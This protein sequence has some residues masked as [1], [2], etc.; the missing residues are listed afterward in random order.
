MN[1]AVRGGLTTFLR[2]R[3]LAAPDSRSLHQY[4]T[5]DDEINALRLHLHDLTTDDWRAHECAVLV[6]LVSEWGHRNA[7]TARGFLDH[8]V[9]ALNVSAPSGPELRKRLGSGLGVW[10]L[11]L[12]GRGD[13]TWNSGLLHEGGYPL[14]FGREGLADLVD[15]IRKAFSWPGLLQTG[16]EAL[17][18]HVKAESPRFP[19]LLGSDDDTLFFTDLLRKFAEYCRLL[20]R[21]DLLPGDREK[22]GYWISRIKPQATPDNMLPFRTPLDSVFVDAFFPQLFRVN[23][24]NWDQRPS[25]P[26]RTP[27]PIPVTT[28]P[29]P[30]APDPELR[31]LNSIRARSQPGRP[32]YTYR[33]TEEEFRAL[34]EEVA[35]DV[36]ARRRLV[37]HRAGRFCL[38]A[39]E[40]L[41]R[42]YAGGPWTW[43]P[44]LEALAWEPTQTDLPSAVRSG[45]E[46][47]Q[48]PIHRTGNSQ[49]LLTTLL[50]EGGLPLSV[51]ADGRDRHLKQYFR[52]LIELSERHGAS[53]ER[54]VH[55]QIRVLPRSFRNEVVSTLSS[56]LADAVVALRK[57]LP[58]DTA[59]DPIAHL[60][61]SDPAWSANLP[62]RVDTGTFREFLRGLLAEPRQPQ[63]QACEPLELV[64]VLHHAAPV[65]LERR[66]RLRDEVSLRDMS[67]FL[68]LTPEGLKPR[69]RFTL[70]MVTVTG[71]RHAVAI[72]RLSVDESTYRL[73]ELPFSPVRDPRSVHHD[74]RIAATTG[75]TEFAYVDVAGGERLLED[76][77]WVFEGG[78]SSRLLAQ[79]SVR[80]RADEVLVLCPH[81]AAPEQSDGL[82]KLPADYQGRLLFSIRGELSWRGCGELWNI[83][84]TGERAERRFALAGQASRC[85]FTGSDF[86]VGMPSV[87]A[88][89][90]DRH[91]TAVPPSQIEVRTTGSPEWRPVGTLTGELDVR[92]RD[93]GE[94]IFRGA[95][96]ALP[97]GTE[98]Q[99]DTRRNAIVIKCALLTEAR[100]N[101]GPPIAAVNGTCVLPYASDRT[102]TVA[103]LNLLLRNGRCTLSVPAPVRAAQFV[104]RDGPTDGPVVFDR[105]GQIRARA[106]SPTTTERFFIEAR[107][108]GKTPWTHIARLPS[109]GSGDGIWELGLSAVREPI[110]NFFAT[111]IDLDTEVELR[112]DTSSGVASRPMLTVRRYEERPTW[113]R[114]DD[115]TVRID[116][117]ADAAQRIGDMGMQLLEMELRPLHDP[118]QQPRQLTRAGNTQWVVDSKVLDE[119]GS[120]LIAGT[121]RGR[122]RLRPLLLPSPGHR[123]TEE[124]SALRRWMAEPLSTVRQKG[125]RQLV[126]ELGSDWNRSEWDELIPILDSMDSLP[127]TTFDVLDAMAEVPDAA[128]AALFRCGGTLD[129]FRRTWRGLEKLPFIWAAVPLS[130]WVST[131]KKLQAWAQANAEP[132][133]VETWLRP[134]VTPLMPAG[135]QFSPLLEVLHGVF[136]AAGVAVTPPAQPLLSAP[137]SMLREHLRERAIAMM[138]RH[139]EDWWPSNPSHL[140]LHFEPE[141][142]PTNGVI[143]Q[144]LAG[145][146]ADPHQLAF[147]IP[148]ALGFAAGSNARLRP[149]SLLACRTIRTFDEVWFDEAHAVGLALAAGPQL[150]RSKK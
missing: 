101:A 11:V 52:A 1:E 76:V 32:L 57:R 124:G 92:V 102:E 65:R 110:E 37:H 27:T 88:L 145:L 142:R 99:V 100:L 20:A 64:T 108:K 113:K 42:S 19:H 109:T 120:W 22:P 25:R 14:L 117:A 115:D 106:V 134:F 21:F 62:L 18:E 111:S 83:S 28:H 116:L 97:P 85:G 56:Q 23:K 49:R 13:A 53:A 50:A 75:E 91:R 38:F 78:E 54:F 8:A 69:S 129:S 63:H 48:R 128:C 61:S 126:I 84:T 93:R 80:H 41:C 33:V 77:P 74:I 79:G 34:R 132:Q 7:R 146:G 3:S 86:W 118:T 47:W 66:A 90:S 133:A 104:G 94:T 140:E 39:A 29:T 70:S 82:T 103:T 31:L 16:D 87:Y 143:E 60:E 55:E 59:V 119:A 72:A 58:R 105:L 17:F 68:G 127:P 130:V 67:R 36:R 148:V 96:V 4:R 125:L 35:A 98:I 10:K 40:A 15:R 44:V 121:I 45:M 43:D 131:A 71:E 46:Y 73:E 123:A 141:L 138:Q 26:L 144:A 95:L 139:S 112:I 6:L 89:D 51:L 5:T 147:R 137:A 9:R 81:D 150:V 136:H 149:S 107:I 135:D 2:A 122:V 114:V 30:R 12:N 24:A